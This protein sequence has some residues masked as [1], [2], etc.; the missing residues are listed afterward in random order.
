MREESC[1][2]VFSLAWGGVWNW[3][4]AGFMEM[5]M[6]YEERQQ[7]AKTDLTSSP[8]TTS[9]QESL[10]TRHITWSR[11]TKETET[12]TKLHRRHRGWH[13]ELPYV[14]TRKLRQYG[15]WR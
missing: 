3:L 2:R 12:T 6:A 5:A 13:N 15:D 1:D 11:G 8:H 7:Q 4:L 10:S 9:R 14:W